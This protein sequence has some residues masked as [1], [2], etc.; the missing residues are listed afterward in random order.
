MRK[1]E[2]FKMAAQAGNY[3]YAD[4]IISCFCLSAPE[5]SS[6][7]KETTKPYPYELKYDQIGYYF[8]R[9]NEQVRIEDAT[10]QEPLLKY[11]EVLEVKVGDIPNCVED[12]V[13]TC[14]NYLLNFIL[15]VYPFNKKI[16]FITKKIKIQDIQ[17]II[18]TNFQEDDTD[19]ATAYT[20]S[21][22]KKFEEAVSILPSLS[23]TCVV[24]ATEKIITP[25][26]G[27]DE[28]KAELD[29]KYAGRLNN[30]VQM[31]EYIKELKAFDEKWLD[32][33]PGLNFIGGGK[34][35]AARQNKFLAIG[36]IS[37]SEGSSN[38]MSFVNRSLYDG[39][40][41]ED[42]PAL[43]SKQRLA[44]YS[45]G[46]ETQ[47]GGVEVKWLI[48]A[49][50]NIN[51][52]VDDCG[53]NVGIPYECTPSN[54][55]FLIG[56]YLVDKTGAVKVSSEEQAGAYLG[57]KVMLRSPMYCRCSRTDYCKTCV[58]DNLSATPYAAGSAVTA[59]GQAFLSLFL[60]RAHG[61]SLETV[62]MDLE[63][64]LF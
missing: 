6:G 62:D 54:F 4:W 22:V 44:S 24:A 42:F 47:L 45:R 52:T 50:S 23:L 25:P 53:T 64:D 58:G 38:D 34:A 16:P 40:T 37:G 21:E 19:D 36:G 43:A 60:A 17:D 35:K 51:I 13:S 41:H 2:Y 18:L 32:G 46:F 49:A 57:K 26:D 15:L 10:I 11:E 27:L 3:K 61:T 8:I 48:R 55:K 9:D 39:W 1:I 31:A 63:T 7:L 29:K 14:G 28:F 20:I 59:N 30:P 12:T 5:S 56:H 33:D